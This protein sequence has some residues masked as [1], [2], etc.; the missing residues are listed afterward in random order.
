M[1]ILQFNKNSENILI[2]D[3]TIKLNVF[4][5]TKIMPESLRFLTNT[6]GPIQYIDPQY[7]EIFNTI[8]KNKS[9]D[10]FGLGIILWEIF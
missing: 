6:I 2:H 7:L 10:I 9:S 3:E 1:I 4:G 8:S 5:L